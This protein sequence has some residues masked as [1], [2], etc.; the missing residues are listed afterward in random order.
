PAPC[1]RDDVALDRLPG[2]LQPQRRGDAHLHGPPPPEGRDGNLR[3]VGPRRR[4]VQVLTRSPTT[5]PHLRPFPVRGE[6]L[7]LVF[8]P[9]PGVF[10]RFTSPWPD[11]LRNSP[12]HRVF[13]SVGRGCPLVVKNLFWLR[14]EPP[15]RSSS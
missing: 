4:P 12:N 6:G 7:F 14:A 13:R 1:L 15:P 8:L 10:F 5:A 2:G 3:L 11:G 9:V